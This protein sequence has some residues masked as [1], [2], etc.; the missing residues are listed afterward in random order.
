MAPPRNGAPSA[1]VQAR[2]LTIVGWRKRGDKVEKLWKVT[3]HDVS[4][5]GDGRGQ[6]F[7]QITDGTL[8]Q[9]G[10]P[11]AQFTAGHGQGDQ[12]QNILTI[13]GGAHLRLLGDGTTLDTEAIH[14]RGP[15]R[16]LW[17]PRPVRITRGGL[18]LLTRKAHLD[19]QL[20]RL[21][22]DALSGE[23]RQLHFEAP[24]GLLFLKD[25]RLELRPVALRMPAGEANARRAVFLADEGRFKAQ[26]VHMK[27]LIAPAARAAAAAGLTLAL[28]NASGAAPAPEKK[29]QKIDVHGDTLTDSSQEMVIANARIIH[30]DTTVTAD[31]M[32]I[33]KDAAGKT[34]RI[35][36]TG[37]PKA[38]ND[39]DEV[40]GE[41]MTVFP[42]ERRVLVEGN[43]RVVVLPKPG[44]APPPSSGGVRDQLKDG[45]MTGDRLEYDYR[46]KNVAAQG[47]LK[48]VSRGRTVTGERLNYTDKT[49][50]VEFIGPVHARDEKGQTFDTAAGAK[51]ALDK[52]G[53]SHVPG[54]FT[55]T[56][57]FDDDEEPPAE[58][59]AKKTAAAP[60]PPAAPD[61]A[62]PPDKK[63]P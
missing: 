58:G 43:F 62:A 24:H 32:V 22:I 14:W 3:A 45:T 52:S 46:N 19:L 11:I 44:E 63:S 9:G 42:K 4:E 30:Q 27:L 28:L 61:K 20:A 6:Q 33:Q 37:K 55:A 25:H 21:T 1:A 39:R 10:R 50:E 54:K 36:A 23:N 53:I 56:L 57:Y 16:Q 38:W 51:L 15:Q 34:E 17:L 2:S 31:H 47:H 7:R 48:L 40:T 59:D 5:G 41:K 18:K 26:E 13:E 29:L 49:Q 35:I 12:D 60:N 8:F